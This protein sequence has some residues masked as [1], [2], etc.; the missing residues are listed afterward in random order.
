M[1]KTSFK[2]STPKK[3][4]TLAQTPALARETSDV[5]A[6]MK[7]VFSGEQIFLNST[8]QISFFSQTIPLQIVNLAGDLPVGLVQASFGAGDYWNQQTF[9]KSRG[10][11]AGAHGDVVDGDHLGAFAW[12]GS[13]G[14][15]WV[16]AADIQ[17]HTIS[18]GSGA[19][20][21]WVR[22]RIMNSS[23]TLLPA[24]FA[25]PLVGT[26][27]LNIGRN[28][29]PARSLQVSNDVITNN[30]VTQ[31]LKLSGTTTGSPTAGIG[32]GMEFE[33]ETS[34][35]NNEVLATVEAIMLD[36]TA[37][38][39]DGAL[40]FKTMAAGAAAVERMRVTND[41][42]N[43][44]LD[45]DLPIDG[46][47]ARFQIVDD[48]S[49]WNQSLLTFSAD[50]NGPSM[51][52]AKSRSGT[53]G[54]HTIV[55]SGDICGTI[56]FYG[57]DG[58]DYEPVAFIRALVDGTPGSN[59]MPGK[60][61]FYTTADGAGGV[62]ERMSLTSTGRL[63]NAGAIVST[64]ASAGVGYATGAGGTVTQSTS[65][66]TSVTLDKVVGR[67]TMNN[68]TLP[69]NSS[70]SF[71]L[72]NSAIEVNDL[73]HIIHAADGSAGGYRVSTSVVFAGGCGITVSNLTAGDL[74]EAIV[75]AFAIIKGAAA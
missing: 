31:L 69:A 62:T 32:V 52:F 73:V 58:T 8:S 55:Q 10:T 74:S 27:S 9:L 13:L 44:N 11:T 3:I 53:L 42:V 56:A 45:L 24:W 35:S 41:G 46:A 67:I 26:G 17:T 70:V 68:A 75:L 43:I 38:S 20:P 65:K 4:P 50:S 61:T 15:N 21:C 40:S 22:L 49:F 1:P 5:L 59:D 14:G 37:G 18:P 12:Y 54:A 19:V 36:G 34:T 63:T 29:H 64:S 28:D 33:V 51:A 7:L 6:A 72:S 16:A 60:L 57:S 2:I 39:E 66:S 25:S 47:S 48:N 71:T 30:A 23:S